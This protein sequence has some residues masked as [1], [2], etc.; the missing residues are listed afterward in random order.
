M[1]PGQKLSDSDLAVLRRWILAG[2]VLED[3]AVAA[4]SDEKTRLAK[5][6]E[7]RITP[8]ERKFWAYQP[9]VRHDP[10]PGAHPVDAFLSKIWVGK[11]LAPSPRA[12]ARTLI[13]RAYLD[14][15]GLPPSLEEVEAFA[16]DPSDEQ[17]KRVIETLL[18]SPHYGERWGRHWLDVVRYA[19]S[20]GFERDFDWHNAWRYRDY[21]VNAF[22]SDKPYDQFVREQ[23]AGDE[24][25]N[26]SDET[27]IATGYLRLGLDNNIKNERTRMDELDDLVGDYVTCVSRADSRLRA[28]PQPQIR[29]YPAERLLPDAG[30][31]FLHERRG[32]PACSGG[33]RGP[34][35]G[36]NEAH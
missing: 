15:V 28:L 26:R 29:S 8:E 7:R 3:T 12:D 32:A 24:L 30:R 1:P 35:P 20:G 19:D 36:G 21:V 31:V 2:A 23:I 25:D 9:P 34:P 6:E 16:S 18:A 10:P 33:G 22:N 17:W 13:R 4:D 5:L 27:M 11:G 14:L